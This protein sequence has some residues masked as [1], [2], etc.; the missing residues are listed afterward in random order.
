VD[1]SSIRSRSDDSIERESLVESLLRSEI[2]KLLS[3]LELGDL[4]SVG[5]NFILEPSEE[6]EKSSTI[7][8][9]A[10]SPSLNL[11]FVLDHLDLTDKV[12]LIDGILFSQRVEDLGVD[13]VFINDNLMILEL[14]S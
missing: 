2:L 10:L 8:D 14:S 13:L 6:L 7:S 12:R 5:V 3:S 1:D 4:L 11:S 9:L